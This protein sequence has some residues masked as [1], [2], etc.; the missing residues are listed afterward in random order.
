VTGVTA[1][2]VYGWGSRN[3]LEPFDL[4]R[5][6]SNPDLFCCATPRAGRFSSTLTQVNMII[7]QMRKATFR[8]EIRDEQEGQ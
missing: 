7:S 6:V 5:G 2:A 8:I 3:V 4:K 1:S